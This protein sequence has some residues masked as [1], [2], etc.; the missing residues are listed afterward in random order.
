MY[1]INYC[2]ILFSL[3]AF[4]FGFEIDYGCKVIGDSNLLPIYKNKIYPSFNILVTEI[5]INSQKFKPGYCECYTE[6]GNCLVELDSNENNKYYKTIV[7][8]SMKTDLKSKTFESI[9]IDYKTIVEKIRADNQTKDDKP[10]PETHEN[11]PKTD[12]MVFSFDF[13]EIQNGQAVR[14]GSI[15]SFTSAEEIVD[16][17]NDDFIYPLKYGIRDF[18]DM[19]FQMT[20]GQ[21]V[22]SNAVECVSS[23]L[24]FKNAEKTVHTRKNYKALDVDCNWG[25]PVMYK[26]SGSKNRLFE[27]SFKLLITVFSLS[28]YYLFL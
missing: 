20:I 3:I 8:F 11:N 12:Y 10:L 6:T 18:G 27:S 16:D 15:G 23:N 22:T 4:S 19:N 28:L 26:S 14:L 21:F 5:K 13:E 25:N 24:D 1:T 9:Y 7:E 2:F 17:S